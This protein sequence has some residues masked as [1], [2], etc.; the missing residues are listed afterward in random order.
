MKV[1]VIG[2]TGRVASHLTR[3]LLSAGIAV[4]IF[5]RNG[6]KA[7]TALVGQGKAQVEI[8]EGPFDDKAT[9]RRAFDGVELACQ[10]LGTSPLQVSLEKGLI[11]AAARMRVGHIVRLSIMGADRHTIYEVGRVHGELDAYLAASGV[12]HTL[13]RPTYYTTNLL[14]AAASIASEDRWYGIAP[15]ARVALIDP[16]DVAEAG[17][18]AIRKPELRNEPIDITGLEAL[19][20]PEMAERLSA[21]PGRTIPFI[22][23]EEPSIRRAMAARTIPEWKVDI[24]IGIEKA[25]E[26]GLHA[27]MTSG[28]RAITGKAPRTVD[29]FIR[30]HRVAFRPISK[31]VPSW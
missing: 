5:V 6:A 22:A 31:T 16:R 17:A 21:L 30:E 29:E 18:A 26:A 15:T 12:P 27:G 7:K 4:R 19:T 2:A 20:F 23:V 25:M 9:L 3:Q 8:V 1:L 11:D 28:L 13:L 14:A 10:A 24:A